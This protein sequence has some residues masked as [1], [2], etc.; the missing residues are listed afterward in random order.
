M[1]Q[2]PVADKGLID[3]ACCKALSAL[4]GD[5]AHNSSEIAGMTLHPLQHLHEST[6][7]GDHLFDVIAGGCQLEQLPH[8]SLLHLCVYVPHVKNMYLEHLPQGLPHSLALCCCPVTRFCTSES[9]LNRARASS[10]LLMHASPSSVTRS[11]SNL[12]STS[13][14]E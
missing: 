10:M 6:V 2:V 4:A 1:H 8:D 9:L 3:V 7:I 14:N 12:R 11:S 5:S 13:R